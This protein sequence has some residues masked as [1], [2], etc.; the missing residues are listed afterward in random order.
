MFRCKLCA[1]GVVFTV[2]CCIDRVVMQMRWERGIH[3]RLLD[4]RS[5]GSGLGLELSQIKIRSSF[6]PEIHGLGEPPL[7]I[8]AKEDNGV[9]G[10]GDNLDNDLDKSTDKRPILGDS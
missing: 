3:R 6:V 10:N 1:F 8:E 7:R 9:N 4:A 2:L 5:V